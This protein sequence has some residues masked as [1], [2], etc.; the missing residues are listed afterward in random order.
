MQQADGSAMPPSSL[1]AGGRGFAQDA[2][3]ES[4]NQNQSQAQ[5]TPQMQQMQAQ[6]AQMQTA[7]QQESVFLPHRL[8]ELE[9][10]LVLLEQVVI[11]QRQTMDL[12]L[13]AL[14]SRTPHGCQEMQ[15]Q[16]SS[17]RL[18]PSG[19]DQSAK[20]ERHPLVMAHSQSQGGGA[21]DPTP[22]EDL[23]MKRSRWAV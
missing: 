12:V 20:E 15:Q 21:A 19:R 17:T 11:G 16:P 18:P 9:H 13:S 3:P 2:R 7:Q 1:N 8:R 23:F 4:A 22:M 6:L 10:R 14:H 5:C